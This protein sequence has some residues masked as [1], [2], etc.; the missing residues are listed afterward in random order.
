MTV[1]WTEIQFLSS[2]YISSKVL[3]IFNIIFFYTSEMQ[4]W[5]REMILQLNTNTWL[6]GHVSESVQLFVSTE[7]RALQNELTSHLIQ[8]SDTWVVEQG[9]AMTVKLIFVI[10][11]E[12]HSNFMVMLQNKV[13][14]TPQQWNLIISKYDLS[15]KFSLLFILSYLSLSDHWSLIK[16]WLVICKQNSMSQTNKTN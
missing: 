5:K 7:K 8:Q 11:I 1:N 9:E 4:L 15:G 6:S 10:S 13:T 12:I 2:E 16:Y 3:K 14:P